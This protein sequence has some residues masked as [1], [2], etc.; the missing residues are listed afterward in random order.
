MDATRV[1][2]VLHTVILV[3]EGDEEVFVGGVVLLLL[4]FTG[5]TKEELEVC[6]VK[7]LRVASCL[8]SALLLLLVGVEGLWK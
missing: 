8:L 3:G 1:S 6:L 2:R 4:L 5:D 7:D